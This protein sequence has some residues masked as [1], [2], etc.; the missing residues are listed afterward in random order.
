MPD[1]S[2]FTKIEDIILHDDIRGMKA[3]RQHM[4]DGW[5]EAAAQLLLDHPGRILIAT[6]FYILRA[7]EPETDG[8][9]GAVAIGAALKEM[10]NTVAYVTDEKCSVAMRAI[11]GDDEVVEFPITNHRESSEFAHNLLVKH[12]PSALVSIERAGL[13]GDGTYRNWKGVDF[14][15]H[16]AKIDHMFNEHPYSVGIGDGGNEI[17]MGNMRA[18]IPSIE[19]LPDDPCVTTTTELITA[20]VSNWGGYGLIAALSVKTG[21]NLLPSVEQGYEWVKDIVAVGAVEGMSG[22]SKDWVDARAPEDDAMCLRDLHALLAAE[23]L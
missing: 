12:A 14:S 19:N 15:E 21:K 20:S 4:P 23:A 7:G 2:I 10:G 9:P 22:E 16:N 11:A 3:L 6:G 13:L 8:P 18:V 17:G 5:L 1:S